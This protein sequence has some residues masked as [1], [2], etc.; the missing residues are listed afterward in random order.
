LNGRLMA[1][2]V[3]NSCTKNY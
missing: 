3:R 1:S 2:Y